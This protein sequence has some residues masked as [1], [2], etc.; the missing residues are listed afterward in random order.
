M[1][2]EPQAKLEQAQIATTPAMNL[3]R[4]AVPM[5]QRAQ[6]D[7][8]QVGEAGG[9]RQTYH[10]GRIAQMALVCHSKKHPMTLSVKSLLHHV[11]GHYRDFLQPARNTDREATSLVA[12]MACSL[13]LT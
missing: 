7:D 3:R 4:P 12:S 2:Q 9:Q 13:I 6:E 11:M 10:A 1:I 8:P 5:R